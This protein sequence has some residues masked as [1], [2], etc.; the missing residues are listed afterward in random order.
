MGWVTTRPSF[1]NSL[2]SAQWLRERGFRTTQLNERHETIDSVYEA[3]REWGY[4]S[5][6]TTRS[7]ASSSRS[8]ASTSSSGSVLFTAALGDARLQVGTDD[9]DHAAEQDPDPRRANG[10]LN[11]VGDARARR[12]RRGDGVARHPPQRGGHQP[13]EHPRR[14]RRDR[15]ARRRRDPQIVGPAGAH[16]RG[17]KPFRMPTH[18]PLGGT[19]IVRP[20]GR[21]CRCPN[22][23]CPSRGLETLNNWVMAA[24]DIEAS[25]SSS[26]ASSGI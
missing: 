3:C 17:T 1:G 16:R 13:Q 19:E 6:S 10:A 22:R 26:S 15:P 11:P 25:A 7:T 2:G 21:S 5:S 12:G 14:R 9:G 8:T 23:A 18:C 24:A 20:E 4:P